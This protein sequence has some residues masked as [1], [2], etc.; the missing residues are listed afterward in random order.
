MGEKDCVEVSRIHKEALEGDYLPTLGLN[1]LKT[2]YKGLLKD[3]ESFGYV[4]EENGKVIGFVTGSENTKNLFKKVIK[5]E[6]T[7]LS[8]YTLLALIKKPCLIKNLIQTF[9][10]NEKVKTDANAE[11]ISIA[12]KEEHRGKDLGKS[13]TKILIN[14]FKKRNI[15]KIK[16]TVNKS[17]IGANKFYQ[18][19][20][21]KH[22]ETFKI[23]GKEMN[24]YTLGI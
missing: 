12:I 6:F 7:P 18:R 21:F 8:Y 1:V 11:L 19:I 20:G 24:L 16:V 9:Q 17:N 22:I 4:A 13:L 10:Y 2:I 3:K 23:Y 15:N 5:Q 14:D